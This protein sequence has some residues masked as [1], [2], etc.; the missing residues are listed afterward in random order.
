M[1]DALVFLLTGA[2]AEG[3]DIQSAVPVEDVAPET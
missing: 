2:K 3:N 1:T